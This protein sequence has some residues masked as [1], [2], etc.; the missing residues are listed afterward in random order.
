[1]L[2]ALMV[3]LLAN[4]VAPPAMAATT[5]ADQELLH[6][7]YPPG[8]GRVMVIELRDV[9]RNADDSVSAT[10]S[11]RAERRIA[12]FLSFEES[13]TSAK[14]FVD[15][16]SASDTFLPL[17]PENTYLLTRVRFPPT[18]SLTIKADKLGY[19]P[20]EHLLMLGVDLALVFIFLVGGTPPVNWGEALEI[21]ARAG[22][23]QPWAVIA[24]PAS[25]FVV[26]TDIAQRVNWKAL[27][28]DLFDLAQEA[29]GEGLK[30]DEMIAAIA[31]FIVDKPYTATQVSAA[32]SSVKVILEGGLKVASLLADLIFAPRHVEVMITSAPVVEAKSDFPVLEINQAGEVW[33]K[34]RN[35][36]AQAWLGDGR[37]TLRPVGELPLGTP[38]R[39]TLSEPVKPNDILHIS[40]PF[41]GSPL[42]GVYRMEWRLFDGEQPFGPRLITDVVVIPHNAGA[43][44][45]LIEP[46]LAAALQRGQEYVNAW[47]EE[48][49]RKITELIIQELLRRLSEVCGVAPAGGLFLLA[50]V[51][52]RK[53]NRHR[54]RPPVVGPVR[55]RSLI[56]GLLLIAVSRAVYSSALY[57]AQWPLPHKYVGAGLALTAAAMLIW[58]LMQLIRF[59]RS[60][61]W[62]GVLVSLALV[63]A[64]AVSWRV[65]TVPPQPLFKAAWTAMVQVPVDA[66]QVAWRAMQSV[67]RAP[68][69][70]QAAYTGTRRSVTISNAPEGSTLNN[71]LVA[72][73]DAQ[74]SGPAVGGIVGVKPGTT[75]NMRAGP[76]TD[77][78]VITTLEPGIRLTV[79]DGP[80]EAND[81][82][83]WLLRSD[84][85]EGWM[86]GKRLFSS[87]GL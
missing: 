59:L 13:G 38:P 83:W 43:L 57:F 45:Q 52:W 8:V 81:E 20:R 14:R 19:T 79:L 54:Q 78:E 28:K 22:T 7:I 12:Y 69:E 63:Y 24:I 29:V 75:V 50:A 4:S 15:T 11:V 33:F 46:I 62:R 80:I 44:R 76:G 74:S 10:I 61:G 67:M 26:V 16:L 35:I 36:G 73:D 17:Y 25:V 2:A 6:I 66:G 39:W 68:G 49:E 40:L 37:I 77:Y 55:W 9:Q 71:A 56:G 51:A 86:A 42:P 70:F 21:A 87:P 34:L 1:V 3:A 30:L 41:S 53:Q 32:F 47:R 85:V 5:E 31:S 58:G 60:I 72:E 18:S 84:E 64:L 23:I 27:A 65:L 82:T 48:L